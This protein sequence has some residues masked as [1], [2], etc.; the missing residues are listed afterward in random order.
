MRRG[1]RLPGLIIA[2]IGVM[3]IMAMLLPTAFWWFLLG[4]GMI[5]VGVSIIKNA[6]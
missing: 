2:G 1:R 6:C 3:I 4:S 5:A